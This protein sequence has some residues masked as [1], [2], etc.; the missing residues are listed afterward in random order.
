MARPQPGRFPKLGRFCGYNGSINMA[1]EN[2]WKS[3]LFEGHYLLCFLM[4]CFASHVCCTA[5]LHHQIVHSICGFSKT[6][7]PGEV[8]DG[9]PHEFPSHKCIPSSQNRAPCFF[10]HVI[11]SFTASSL[12]ESHNFWAST[13][14]LT[15]H[16]SLPALSVLAAW[17][18]ASLLP[19]WPS[20]RI[21]ENWGC[22]KTQ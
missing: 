21:R 18:F 9:S 15:S 6:C 13:M 2:Q 16:E 22:L 10:N 14:G 17:A 4:F 20:L 19:L 12:Y 1:M 11:H 7:F 5:K 3:R 8:E